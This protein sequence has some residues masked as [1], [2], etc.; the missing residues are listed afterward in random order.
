MTRKAVS[1]K[2][3][4]AATAAKRDTAMSTSSDAARET[5]REIEEATLAPAERGA[6]RTLPK[7]TLYAHQD[8]LKA[9]R[10]LAVEDGVQAQEILRA[11]VRDYLATRGYHFTDLT[12]GQ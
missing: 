2:D 10:R 12:T 8:V 5:A 11:A 9:I 1:L 4:L 6:P 3:K 7:V